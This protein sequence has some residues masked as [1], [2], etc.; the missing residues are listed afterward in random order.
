MS[1]QDLVAVRIVK[2]PS[3]EPGNKGNCARCGIRLIGTGH[4]Y[5][6]EVVGCTQRRAAGG[7]NHVADRQPTGR[8][9]CEGCMMLQKSSEPETPAM[10]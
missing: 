1:L 9:L 7:S 5:W 6:E 10:L 3:A 2:V 8:F 4:S